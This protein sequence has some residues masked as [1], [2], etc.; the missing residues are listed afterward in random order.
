VHVPPRCPERI[1]EALRD[2][3]GDEAQRARLGAAAA[4]RARRYS[5]S[6][7]ADATLRAYATVRAP[8]EETAEAVL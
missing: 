7:V 8:A 1:A 3:L 2:V 5:W 6:R 4:R